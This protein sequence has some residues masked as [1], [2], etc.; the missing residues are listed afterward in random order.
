MAEEIKPQETEVSSNPSGPVITTEQRSTEVLDANGKT[1]TT[2]SPLSKIFE[3]IA[4]G[5]DAKEAVSS[6]M[7]TKGEGRARGLFE[8]KEEKAASDQADAGNT[9]PEDVV[10]PEVKT[11]VVVEKKTAPAA[12]PADTP[13]D[14]EVTEEELKV[15]PHDKPKTARRIDKLLKKISD[16]EQV[17]TTTRAEAQ[18]K[19]TKLAKLEEDLAK[20]S[21]VDPMADERVKQHMDELAMYRRRYSL[22]SDPSVK[23]RY[24]DRVSGAEESI[25]KTL[26]KWKAPES[27]I[28]VIKEEGGWLKFA[29]SSRPI[30]LQNG[31]TITA[32]ELAESIKGELPI[33]ERRSIESLEL[34]QIQTKRDKDVYF[35][36]E[37]KKAKDYF[38]NQEN[39]TKKQREEQT[40]RFE[41][42]NKLVGDWKKKFT[43][44]NAWLNEKA[45]DA[46]LTPEQKAE[47]EDHNKHAKQLNG[48]IDKHLQA[49]DMDAM[50]EVLVDSIRYHQTRR[51]LAAEMD[52]NKKLADQLKA[53]QDEIDRFKKADSPVQRGGS[54]RAAPGNGSTSGENTKEA[55]PPSLEDAFDAIAQGKTFDR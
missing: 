34:E 43:T 5:K 53:K 29:D 45:V 23:Q 18:E 2:D 16:A 8:T 19:A 31:K 47:I 26:I 22:E 49:K 36:E 14:E 24:D 42:A 48:L 44:E 3:K 38:S 27:L 6:V 7:K 50:L 32:A 4:D 52:K 1:L 28:A 41:Q 13:S 20:V 37:T 46:K 17:I 30:E 51:E 21:S 40:Q 15:L 10:E 33:S 9:K 35:Q 55:A 11:E 12:K 39:M 25:H 54:L